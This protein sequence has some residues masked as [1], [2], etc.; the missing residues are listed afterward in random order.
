VAHEGPRYILEMGGGRDLALGQRI[1]L[2]PYT[3]YTVPLRLRA[4]QGGRLQI[5]LCERNLLYA[6]NFTPKCVHENIRLESSEGRFGNQ[7]FEIDSATVG[8]S[9]GLS[10]WPTVLM[11][12]YFNPGQVLELDSIE[13]L[14][15]NGFN[16]LRNSSFRNGLDSW[17]VYH[18]DYSRLP[19]HVDNQ[20]VQL[21]FE[22]G[23]VGIL[24]FAALLGLMLKAALRPRAPT[25]LMPVY[26]AAVIAL[27]SLGLFGSPLDS[28]RVSWLFYFCL[29]S[30]VAKLRLN[31]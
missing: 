10:G 21:W 24:L 9:R 26:C 18:N 2:E 25:S 28:A 12:Q 7:S 8:E 19:W 20:F 23:W 31:R 17:F 1:A 22:S 5:S 27:C 6:S 13:M 30:S 11:L 29:F 16:R 14:D 15:A 4:E 3:R